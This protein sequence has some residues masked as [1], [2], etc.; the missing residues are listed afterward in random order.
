MIVSALETFAELLKAKFTLPGSAS[1][2]D[3]LKAPVATAIETV[4]STFGLAVSSRTET[5]LADHKVRPDVAIYVKGLICGYIELKAPGL[6]AD[7]PK[8]K[9]K[10]NKEQ[11]EKLKGL[12]NL[13]YTD[14]REW[15]LYRDGE[16]KGVIVRFDD[17]P[18]DA[19]KTAITGENAD[20]F[21]KLIRE[22]L[23]WNPIVPHKPPGLASYLAPLTRF[24]RTEVE[25]PLAS[26]A[27][28]SGSLPP[29]GESIFSPKLITRSLP[30][31]MRRRSLTR[32]FLR[33]SLAQS[34][35]RQ[36]KQ[37][38]PSTKT[39]VFWRV[40]WNFWGNPARAM[41]CG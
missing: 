1:P 31:L 29:N 7:A 25:L 13:I 18:T 41:S 23:F 28:T 20:N 11:W 14:G 21:E 40:R 26:A 22:F 35:L 27:P 19:G 12:P 2:E 24:L 15:A 30:M 4:G 10:H 39:M 9:G 32:C 6:G 33:V 8:L 16:R 5:H 34:T 38:R 37:P 3:Q 17:D 36:L